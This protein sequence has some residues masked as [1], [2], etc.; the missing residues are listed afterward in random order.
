MRLFA[1][2]AYA[3]LA[4]TESLREEMPDYVAVDLI[5]PGFVTSELGPPEAMA[6]TLMGRLEDT[7]DASSR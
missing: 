6:R 4:L 2:S 3:A 7:V 5:C 1:S